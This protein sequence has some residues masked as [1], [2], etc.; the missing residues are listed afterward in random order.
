MRVTLFEC[1]IKLSCS[2][3]I[4]QIAQRHPFSIHFLDSSQVLLNRR[5]TGTLINGIGGF[6]KTC[7]KHY[8]SVESYPFSE[9]FWHTLLTSCHLELPRE[10]CISVGLL[11]HKSQR[12]LVG[13]N[14][15]VTFPSMQE[16]RS[17]H[18]VGGK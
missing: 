6:D 18:N 7:R 9:S 5:K 13:Q 10:R 12:S 8:S 15:R 1:I 4:R 16:Q 2:Y 17:P 3:T 11:G 14:L